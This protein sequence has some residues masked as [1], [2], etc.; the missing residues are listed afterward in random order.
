MSEPPI[1]RPPSISREPPSAEPAAAIDVVSICDWLPP[2]FGAVGQY[3]VLAARE[4]AAAGANVVLVGLSS[5]GSARAAEQVGEGTLTTVRLSAAAYAK[6][7]TLARLWW[8]VVTN[9][10]LLLAAWPYLRRAERVRFTGSP[11]FFLHWIA[12]ANLL[13]RR[14]L[15]YRISDFHPECAIAERGRCGPLLYLALATTRFWRRRV[16][17]FEALGLDQVRRLIAGGIDPARV[18]LRPDPSPATITAETAPLPRPSAADGAV[19]LLY[20][21][22]WGVAHDAATFLSA[23]RAHHVLGSGRVILW[24]NALGAKAGE[25]RT[26]LTAEGI[27]F[28]DGSPVPLDELAGLLVT[29]DAHLVTL[30]DPFVGYV[31][32]SKIHGAIA[33]RRPVLFVGSAGSDVHRLAKGAE[34]PFYRRV[35]V[36]ADRQL[37]EVFE[38]LAD[39]VAA[40]RRAALT[41]HGDNVVSFLEAAASLRARRERHPPAR[42]AAR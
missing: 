40:T 38:A 9:T 17:T 14:R 1:D 30:L 27:P 23:Y 22:N 18:V 36:G 6:H 32:P 3:A 25:V 2:D 35:D 42:P 11:P 5:A 29:P 7:R 12:A 37:E 4:E 28:V 8:T 16:D 31:L 39:H 34:L 13:L 33:S 19:L 26:Q 15:V 10:R 41:L 24:L 20:S 21:G